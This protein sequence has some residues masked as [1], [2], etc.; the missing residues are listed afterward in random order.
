MRSSFNVVRVF[1]VVVLAVF[2]SG[3]TDVQ[4]AA[5]FVNGLVPDWNQPYRYGPPPGGPTDPFP[6]PPNPPGAA[7]QWNAWCA[8]SSAANLAGRARPTLNP[9]ATQVRCSPGLRRVYARSR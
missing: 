8:P 4:A 7:T 2:L 3:A 1:G 5:K 9:Y 6:S